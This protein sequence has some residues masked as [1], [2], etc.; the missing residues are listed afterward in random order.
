MEDI[1]KYKKKKNNSSKSS[2]RSNHKHQYKTIIM[3][4]FM[5]WIWASECAICGRIKTDHFTDADF[6]RPEYRD[7]IGLCSKYFYTYEEL[8]RIYPNIKIIDKSPWETF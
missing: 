6:I 3:R 7:T 4:G 5:G 2:K 1:P 8:K